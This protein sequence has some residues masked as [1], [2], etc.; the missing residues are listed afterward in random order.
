MQANKFQVIKRYLKILFD[1]KAE[2]ESYEETIAEIYQS[3]VFKGTKLWLLIV[4]VI[5]AAEGLNINSKTAIIGAMIISPLMGPSSSIGFGLY[6]RDIS[7]I[8]L[9]IRNFVIATTVAL[10]SASILYLVSPFRQSTEELISYSSPTYFDILFAFLGG[11]ATI[12]GVINRDGNKIFIGIAV[13]TSCI[14]PLATAGYGIANLKWDFFLGGMYM[15]MI[16]AYFIC[17]RA[18]TMTK[19]LNFKRHTLQY[20]EYEILYKIL[21]YLT[22][23]MTLPAFWLTY[24][25]YCRTNAVPKI[26]EILMR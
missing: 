22:V 23:L 15:Y 4:A 7:L 18:F 1:L 17:L 8:R 24:I 16:N 12:I 11:I 9:A 19:I 3:A 13:A 10:I 2:Q 26:I 6:T 5:I 21:P 25:A 20:N 14:P